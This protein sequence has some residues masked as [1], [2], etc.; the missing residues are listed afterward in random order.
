MFP[1]PDF[2]LATSPMFAGTHEVS[3]FDEILILAQR[4]P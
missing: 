2:F 1:V 4:N 3:I